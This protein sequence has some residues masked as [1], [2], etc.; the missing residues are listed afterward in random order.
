MARLTKRPLYNNRSG[1]TG[2]ERGDDWGLTTTF[3][4]Y[5]TS[6]IRYQA[7]WG[8]DAPRRGA[9]VQQHSLVGS[10]S[11]ATGSRGVTPVGGRLLLPYPATP[12]RGCLG[13]VLYEGS[14]VLFEDSYHDPGI[15]CALQQ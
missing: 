9:R 15:Q 14:K 11:G 1:T 4:L 5:H 3:C 12:R 7:L 2:V 10:F 13:I 6:M 8:R